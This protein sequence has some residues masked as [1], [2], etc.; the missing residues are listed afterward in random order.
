[1][2]IPSRGEQSENAAA[3]A[4]AGGIEV[5]VGVGGMEAWEAV[6]RAGAVP[7]KKGRV[8]AGTRVK[9][10]LTPGVTLER[11]PGCAQPTNSTPT[12]KLP[13]LR[14]N[15]LFILLETHAVHLVV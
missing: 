14:R 6:A 11:L 9:A 3:G 13:R 1:M 8:A 7:V 5:E 15:G 10:G 4:P 2:V 12:S